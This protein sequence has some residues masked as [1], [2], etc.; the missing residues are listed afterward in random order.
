MVFPQAGEHSL[1]RHPIR[2]K[3][4]QLLGEIRLV[5]MSSPDQL[6]YLLYRI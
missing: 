2:Q 4:G 3:R 6:M 1:G 5:S